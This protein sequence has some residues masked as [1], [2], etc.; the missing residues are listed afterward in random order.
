MQ[1]KAPSNQIFCPTEDQIQYAEC[2]E[3]MSPY[4][5]WIKGAAVYCNVCSGWQEMAWAVPCKL[6]QGRAG[7]R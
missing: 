7:R 3:T 1:S 2:G 4:R 5:S 6:Y